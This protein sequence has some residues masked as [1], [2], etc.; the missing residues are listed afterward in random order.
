MNQVE[1]I[2][3]STEIN[4]NIPFNNI[5]NLELNEWQDVFINDFEKPMCVL[6]HIMSYYS[7]SEDSY[8][9]SSQNQLS[10]TVKF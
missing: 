4:K 5:S 9:R 8:A 3:N 7:F 1:R 10:L 2:T 6:F